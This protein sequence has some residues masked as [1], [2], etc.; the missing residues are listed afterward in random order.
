MLRF[1]PQ[2]HGL[3]RYVSANASFYDQRALGSL[4]LRSRLAFEA[5]EELSSLASTSECS[6][7]LLSA[8]EALVS[9][10][11][12]LPLVLCFEVSGAE[13][14]FLEKKISTGALTEA[15]FGTSPAFNFGVAVLMHLSMNET[16][17][18]QPKFVVA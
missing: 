18:H 8:E 7:L 10:R 12:R 16:N 15:V 13:R 6:S 11:T 9:E 14:C 5:V 17:F 2:L 4:R 1:L 3:S